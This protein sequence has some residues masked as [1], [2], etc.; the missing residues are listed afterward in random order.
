M[1][2]AAA[3]IAAVAGAAG[4]YVSYYARVAAGA[5]IA[6]AMLGAVVVA[7]LVPRGAR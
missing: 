4:L 6:G 3:G 2:A 5:S 7:R 1:I